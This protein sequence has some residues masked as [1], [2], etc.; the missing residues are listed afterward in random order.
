MFSVRVLCEFIQVTSPVFP[1]AV[2]DDHASGKP[3]PSTFFFPDVSLLAWRARMND[4]SNMNRSSVSCTRYSGTVRVHV[5]TW[6]SA[7]EKGK[8][9]KVLIYHI[10][11]YAFVLI[12][13]RI[14]SFP[15][16]PFVVIL[17][18]VCVN[19]SP[20]DLTLIIKTAGC[21]YFGFRVFLN[22]KSKQTNKQKNNISDKI[23][24]SD[25][26]S[27]VFFF[28]L[29]QQCKKKKKKKKAGVN[30][31]YRFPVSEMSGS[32]SK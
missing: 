8:I 14:H 6:S 13:M 21:V 26:V 32:K 25:S 10:F 20:M 28:H 23:K 2:Q 11:F 19:F 24:K 4:A 18:R 1:P 9:H 7:E 17:V 30:L 31:N 15:F 5:P 27:N 3:T 16:S 22:R 12:S 29:L